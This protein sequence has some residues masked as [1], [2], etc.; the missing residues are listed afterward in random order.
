MENDTNP[1][2]LVPPIDIVIGQL[3]K[4]IHEEGIGVNVPLLAK[5]LTLWKVHTSSD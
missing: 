4:L 1:F 2:P 3:K 5:N